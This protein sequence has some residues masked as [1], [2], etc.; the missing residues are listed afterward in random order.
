MGRLP[1]NTVNTRFI[2]KGATAR[3]AK[4]Y[5]APKK[6]MEQRLQI[7][8]ECD[9]ITKSGKKM[10]GY[11]CKCSCGNTKIVSRSSYDSGKT[12]SCGCLI[13]EFNSKRG[14]YYGGSAHNS[15][16]KFGVDEKVIRNLKIKF[17]SMKG[18]CYDPNNRNYSNYG[19]RGI[20]ICDEWLDDQEA[21]IRWALE[22]GYE[23]RK[24]IDRI[25][26]DGNYEPSN[27]RW[28]TIAEQARNTRR[29]VFIQYNGESY[30]I[31][32]LA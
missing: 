29:N 31:T 22:S 28:A 10:P 16:K 6:Q 15:A 1:S 5:T 14:Q 3:P 18:R 19:G 13:R 7:V 27:C 12:R 32:D 17:K 23:K 30:I 2:K 26:V 9:Y 24:S 4:V 25:D 20:V 21:F 11:L 8:N